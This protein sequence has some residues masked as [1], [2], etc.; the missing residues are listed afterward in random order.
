MGAI[1][2][3]N[4]QSLTDALALSAAMALEAAVIGLDV[5]AFNLEE[6]V[7]NLE[8]AGLDVAVVDPDVAA[9]V[10]LPVVI[11]LW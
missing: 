2:A 8:A 3:H 6:T 1:F 9:I 5:A 4:Q 7:N 10:T 11:G